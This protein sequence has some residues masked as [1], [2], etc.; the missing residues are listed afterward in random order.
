VIDDRDVIN[1]WSR[2]V[3]AITSAGRLVN[4]KCASA[5][6]QY[7]RRRASGSIAEYSLRSDNDQMLI[8]ASPNW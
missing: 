1:S 7:R 3:I 8:E 2:S 4:H 5:A 6:L